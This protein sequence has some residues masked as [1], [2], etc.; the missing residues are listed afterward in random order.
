MALPLAQ[1]LPLTLVGLVV[2]GLFQP[3]HNARRQAIGP[4]WDWFCLAVSCCGLLV[5][6]LVIGH[7][8]A[9]N[10]VPQHQA[11]G[12]LAAFLDRHLFR[13]PAPVICRQFFDLARRGVVDA[14]RLAGGNLRAGVLAV[15]RTDHAGRRGLSAPAIRPG[16]CSNW[17]ARTPA[18]VPSFRHW[19]PPLLPFSLRNVLRREYSGWLAVVAGYAGLEFV[20]RY[21]SEQRLELDLPWLVALSL[22]T[23]A[24]CVLRF[25]KRHTRLLKVEGR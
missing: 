18:F 15:L 19:R 3:E 12:R 6:A 16:V 11:P 24:Y 10:I 21:L 1:F 13:R 14:A 2:L 25:L 7:G 17:S 22:A 23:V 5:C 20:R 8:A 4:G 9:A